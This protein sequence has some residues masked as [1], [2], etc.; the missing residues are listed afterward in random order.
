[1][2]LVLIVPLAL[3][4]AVTL[5]YDSTPIASSP[6]VHYTG[7]SVGGRTFTFTY[8]A[9]N[10]SA[11]HKGL[12]GA[13]VTANTTMLFVFPDSGYY[14]FWMSGVNSSLDI[15]WVDAPPGAAHGT[16][17]YMESQ[18]PP[19]HASVLCPSYDPTVKANYVIEAKGG[20][21][22]ANGIKVGTAV[23]FT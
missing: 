4:A 3:F 15:I 21:A 19:C 7:F 18:A 10:D 6:D 14:P 16:V 1:M 2:A 11:L 5:V 8:V 20:F 23:T 17:A 13:K 9:T 22:A 12:M